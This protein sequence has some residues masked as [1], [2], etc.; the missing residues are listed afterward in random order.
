MKIHVGRI[1]GI[2]SLN[3]QSQSFILLINV[4]TPAIVGVLTLM[5]WI[6]SMLSQV[7]HEK[8]FYNWSAWLSQPDLVCDVVYFVNTYLF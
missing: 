5:S 3:L 4:K 7:E 2:F 8:N 1:N 6:D